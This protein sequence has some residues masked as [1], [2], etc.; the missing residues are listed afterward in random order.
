ME[1]VCDGKTV[2]IKIEDGEDTY[3]IVK[4]IEEKDLEATQEITINKGDDNE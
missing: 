2:D 3:D 4:P 1:L